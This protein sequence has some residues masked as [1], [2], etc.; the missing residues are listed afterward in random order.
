VPGTSSVFELERVLNMSRLPLVSWLAAAVLCLPVCA[1][2]AHA[3]VSNED[4]NS[5]SVIDTGSGQTVATLAVGKRPR[6]IKLSPDGR[7]L[8]VAVSGVPKCPPGVPDEECAKRPRDWAADG[9]AVLDTV[10]HKPVAHLGAGSD[11]EQFDLSRD[12]RRLYVSNEDGAALTV[13]D[14]ASGALLAAIPV[15]HEPEGVRVSPDDRWVL[16]TSETDSI[17][18]IIDTRTLRVSR[19]AHV[20][21]RPRDLAFAPDGARAYITGEADATIHQVTI[22]GGEAEK[23]LQLA[24]T[25]R[26][27]GV[28]ADGAR[29]RLYVSTGRGGSVAVVDLSDGAR[30]LTEIKVGAR[31]WGIALGHDGAEVYTA[32]GPSDDVSVIDTRSN[33]VVRT[34]PVGKGPWGIVL[35]P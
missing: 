12:G 21:L 35:G 28:V 14:A 30:L 18:S 33:T 13:I 32:N 9:I 1:L 25:G 31:P 20:G 19:T 5:V 4:G 2:G 3:Y 15:G 8:Y 22:P 24:R 10:T 6:G 23:L 11:P 7:R 34:I 29:R 16:V 27:M 17:V 26:P